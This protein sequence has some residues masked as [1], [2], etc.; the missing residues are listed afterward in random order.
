M[1]RKSAI[2]PSRGTGEVFSRRRS[3]RSTAPMI[4]ATRPT[5]GES[6]ITIASAVSAP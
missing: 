5:A 2:P 3:G 6:A 1:P 4:R